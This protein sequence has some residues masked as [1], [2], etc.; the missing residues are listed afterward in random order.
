MVRVTDVAELEVLVPDA[1]LCQYQVSPLG[2][3]TRVNTVLPQLLVMVGIVGV[4]GRV[5][6]L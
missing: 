4:A 2:G 1:E 5:L 3:A 6:M